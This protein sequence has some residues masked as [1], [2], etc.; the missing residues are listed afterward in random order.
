MAKPDAL[1]T[2]VK[3]LTKSEKRYFRL[4]SRMQGKDHNYL[5]LFDTLDQMEQYHE[6]AIKQR[7]SGEPF[8]KQLHV[9]KNYLR[10]LI[11]KSLR[12]YHLND[13]NAAKLKA[14]LLDVEILFKRDLL[15]LCYKAA[16]KAENLARR[17]DDNLALLEALNWKHR[18]LLNMEGVNDSKTILNHI[19]TE[20]QQILENLGHENQYWALT[21]NFNLNSEEERGGFRQNPYLTEPNKAL[22]RRSKILYYH[23]LYVTNILSDDLPK[24]E[25][26]IEEL[27]TYLEAD[28][29]QLRDDPGPYVTAINNK[30]GLYLNQKQLDSIPPLLDKIRSVP[31]KLG[32]KNSSHISVKLLIRTYNVELETYRDS[33][34]VV[35][36]I[37]L[38]PK[39]KKFLSTH[40]DSVPKEY[41]ILF[42]YQFA[43]LFFMDGNYKSALRNVNEV[44]SYRHS[45]ERGDIVGYAQFLNLIIH[46]ELGNTTVLK[47]SV[48]ASRRFLKKRGNLVE[49]EKV[50]LKL[51]SNISTRAD[52][53]HK[54]LFKKTHRKLFE[55]P[56]VITESHLDYLDFRYWLNS[57]ISVTPS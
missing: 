13:S 1:F 19:G 3:S 28:T 56:G 54:N 23:L 25:Q 38:I 20:E 2:L 6:L 50:L 27:I 29:F 42:H 30:I 26:S 12:G 52:S 5:E 31:D 46:Y 45:L 7:F 18:A 15:N 44:L 34:Q 48:D 49:F 47:Y 53:Q 22:T 43:Y 14:Y 10:K 21:I 16:L 11:L 36:G 40:Q 51:F 24:A 4:F 33:G 37:K 8:L 55:T 57:K 35:E 39:I 9:T 32:L 17:T 41:R